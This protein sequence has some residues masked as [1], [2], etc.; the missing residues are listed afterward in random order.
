VGRSSKALC[1]IAW[2]RPGAESCRSS[3]WNRPFEGD[4]SWLPA[5][6][7]RVG[8]SVGNRSPRRRLRLVNHRARG[9]HGA[10]AVSAEYVRT[11]HE[12]PI[13]RLDGRLHA[14]SCYGRSGF[15]RSGVAGTHVFGSAAPVVHGVQTRADGVVHRRGQRTNS[16]FDVAVR[17]ATQAPLDSS[18]DR[19]FANRW[20]DGSTAR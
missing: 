8:W 5:L 6:Q 19:A 18:H 9:A 16:P 20:C 7:G 4:R 2:P 12:L 15:K 14:V 10:V 17:R 11:Y 13:T 1:E 3:C